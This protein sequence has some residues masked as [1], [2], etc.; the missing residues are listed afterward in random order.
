MNP[1]INPEELTNDQKEQLR[2]YFKI[3]NDVIKEG[4]T[5][6]Q[7][8][9]YQKGAIQA[10][11]H[12]FGYDF[13]KEKKLPKVKNCEMTCSACP[14]QWDIDLED[15][16]YVYARYRWGFLYLNL[17]DERI[18]EKQVGGEWDGCMS[19]EKLI[20]LTKGVLDWSDYER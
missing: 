11:S 12:V 20:E 9:E 4:K 15:G 6:E 14:S 3:Y 2:E 19:T 5:P 17:D 10:L 16:R 8:L 1:I 7:Y 18:F 13:F